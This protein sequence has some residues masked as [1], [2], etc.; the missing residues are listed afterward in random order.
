MCYIIGV[1]VKLYTKGEDTMAFISLL[2]PVI[3]CIVIVYEVSRNLSHSD[4]D[5]R[6]RFIQGRAYTAAFFSVSALDAAVIFLYSRGIVLMGAEVLAALHLYVGLLVF[7]IYCVAKDAY[8]SPGDEKSPYR[9]PLFLGVIGILNLVGGVIQARRD[10][11]I[12]N[13]MLTNRCFGLLVGVSFT[14]LAVVFLAK[15]F[16]YKA[17]G[18]DE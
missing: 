14:L 8:F 18:E 7:V 12:E 2:V 17:K 4:H 16:S 1:K 10:G 6:Q 5:E 15:T 3:L 9:Y 13:G 11:I